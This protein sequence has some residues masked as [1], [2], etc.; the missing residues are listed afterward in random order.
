MALIIKLGEFLARLNEAFSEALE[1][2]GGPPEISVRAGG[3]RRA[4]SC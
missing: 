1:Q 3:V 4:C 2:A